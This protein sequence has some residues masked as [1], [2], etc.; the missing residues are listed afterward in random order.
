MHIKIKKVKKD[1]DKGQKDVKSLL[2]ADIK[3]DKKMKGK[4]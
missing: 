1:L 4:C 2:K 3:M